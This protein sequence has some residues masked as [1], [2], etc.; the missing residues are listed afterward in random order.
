MNQAGRTRTEALLEKLVEWN[1]KKGNEAQAQAVEALQ[2]KV[3]AFRIRVPLI[4]KFSAGKSTL[5]NLLLDE[6]ELLEVDILPE[7]ALPTEICYAEEDHVYFYTKNSAPPCEI[8]WE[9]YCNH[10]YKTSCGQEYKAS[11]LQKI[12]MTLREKE[13]EELPDLDL[14]DLPGFDSGIEDHNRILDSGALGGS[15]YLLVFPM[16]DPV[17]KESMVH[18]LQELILREGTVPVGVV[19]TRAS[20]KPK[21]EWPEVLNHLRESLKRYLQREFPVFVTDRDCPESVYGLRKFL[22][23]LQDQRPELVETAYHPQAAAMANELRLYLRQHKQALELSGADLEA[24]EAKLQREIEKLNQKMQEQREKFQRAA[25]VCRN[26]ILE[27]VERT[28][29]SNESSYLQSMMR[30]RSPAEQLNTDVR[31]AVIR[32]VKTYFEPKV[33]EYVTQVQDSLQAAVMVVDGSGMSSAGAAVGAGIG[34]GVAAGGAAAFAGGSSAVASLLG[35]SVLGT[36]LATALG[37]SVTALSIPVIGIAIAGIVGLA[38]FAANKAR[39]KEKR[40][41]YEQKLRAEV[42]PSILKELR[43]RL[44]V[45]LT[46]AVQQACDEIQKEVDQKTELLDKSLQEVRKKRQ[47]EESRLAQERQQAEQELTEWEEICREYGC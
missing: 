18:I 38:A 4:G 12:R 37:S 25:P 47:S 27:D 33:Q 15:A 5:L 16:D 43:Q 21:E 41:E 44:D 3:R 42:F 35:S 8:S 23:E 11:E 13:L 6:A 36:G 28:L 7:T 17:V 22:K 34:A 31:A 40:Q 19:V 46:R 30:G 20:R 26:Q 2:R 10:E 14:V 29:H 24:K 39:E 32:G 45:E 1:T 9:Q